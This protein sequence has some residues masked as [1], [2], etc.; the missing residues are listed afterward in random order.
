MSTP[1]THEEPAK[2]DRETSYYDVWG[3]RVRVAR[4]PGDPDRT[5]LL[6][7]NG[8]CARLELVAPL[9]EQLSGREIVTFEF[10]G[11]GESGPARLPYT[12]PMAAAFTAR[13]LKVLGYGRVDVFGVSWGGALAQ[14]FALQHRRRCR[15]L[16][17][18]ATFAGVPTV[19]GPLGVLRELATPRRFNDPAHR[20][21]VAG[22]LYGGA[23]RNTD[24]VVDD[25]DHRY[26]RT[27]RISYLLQQLAVT[28]WSSQP[29]LWT[30]PQPTLVMAGDDDPIIPLVNARWMARLIPNATLHIVHDGHLF[31]LSDAARTASVMTEFLDGVTGQTWT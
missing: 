27:S 2:R 17:L 19:P 24:D 1:V 13:L 26:G 9:A 28:G 21:E 10:P 15:R 3:H 29:L 8:I 23:A 31:F 7:L 16:V 25:L 12:L 4:W 14:Q 5:P 18:A 11:S 30:L 22:T 6:L 20:R